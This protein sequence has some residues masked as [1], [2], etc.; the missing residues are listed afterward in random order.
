MNRDHDREVYHRGPVSTSEERGLDP[1]GQLDRRLRESRSAAR[2][3]G[4][5]S[6]PAGLTADFAATSPGLARTVPA[7]RPGRDAAWR[8]AATPTRRRPGSRQRRVTFH[9]KHTERPREASSCPHTLPRRLTWNK[10]WG[11][12]HTT[13]RGA[14]PTARGAAHQGLR[15]PRRWRSEIERPPGPVARASPRTRASGHP[16]SPAAPIRARPR[17]PEQGG[18]CPLPRFGGRRYTR[19]CRPRGHAGMV[20]RPRAN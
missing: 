14:A 3:A 12:S 2:S 10:Q 16:Q 18:A 11:R 4:P 15:P 13:A 5:R 1:C 19:G 7:P 8:M 20:R 17:R 6:C 9:V